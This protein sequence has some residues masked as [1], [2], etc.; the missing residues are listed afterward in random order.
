MIPPSTHI[1]RFPPF[2][3][4]KSASRVRIHPKKQRRGLPV[5]CSTRDG[6]GRWDASR[7][8]MVGCCPPLN[9]V[10]I[11]KVGG[12]CGGEAAISIRTSRIYLTIS[13][14]TRSFWQPSDSDLSRT[15]NFCSVPVGRFILFTPPTT[16]PHHSQTHLLCVSCLPGTVPFSLFFQ[17]SHWP[18]YLHP[19]KDWDLEKSFLGGKTFLQP[20]HV[21]VC[22]SSEY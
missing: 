21:L 22:P 16:Q 18:R 8:S 11:V 6:S 10:A 9:V 12:M 14:T 7:C 17:S 20:G 5:L 3:T 4:G 2:A 1:P 19:K 15:G 13:W